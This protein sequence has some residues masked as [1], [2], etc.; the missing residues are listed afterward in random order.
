MYTTLSLALFTLV[1]LLP[2][3]T[4]AG[5]ANAKHLPADARWYIHLDVE[6]ARKT[7]LYAQA[8]DLVKAQFPLEE[9]A[10]QLKSQIGVNPLTDITAVTVYNNSFAK[11]V[12]AVVIYARVDAGLLNNAIAQNPGYKET[13]YGK[14]TL[15]EW[16][17]NNDGKQK[18][19]CFYGDGIV[20]MADKPDTLKLAVDTL[21]GAHPA[22]SA[23]V[24]PAPPGAFLYGSADLAQSD[25]KNVSQLLS[26]SEAA[27]AHVA[28]QDGNLVLTVNLTARTTEQAAQIKKMID[29]VKAFGQ[30]ATRDF[31]TASSLIEKLQVVADG[32]KVTATFQHPSSTILQTLQKLDQE[33]K[34]KLA[35][36][37]PNGL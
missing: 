18:N 22:G 3:P 26:N 29:G 16:T 4:L 9:V 30:L 14:H 12:A 13:A 36:P 31:P 11:E 5:G 6:A 33:K 37:Q 27:N 20:L 15:L 23:L 24:K 17:D 35:K 2:H 34:A 25:D 19:G 1:S 7:A 21:D 28:E 32:A 10:A 8:L